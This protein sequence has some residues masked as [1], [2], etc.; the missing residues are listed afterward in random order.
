MVQVGRRDVF[1]E[2]GGRIRCRIRI[3]GIVQGVGFRPFVYNTATALGLCG[4]VL[5]D[6]RGVLVEAEGEP[7]KVQE[8]L[9]R[10][11]QQPPRLARIVHVEHEELAPVGYPR[12]EIAFS[13]EGAEKEALV[14]PDVALC[15]DCARESFDPRDRHYLYPFTNCTNCGPRFTIVIAVPYDRDKTSMAGFAMCPDCAREYHDPTNRRFHAQPVACPACGPQVELRDAEGNLVP[16]DWR[17]NCWRALAEGKIVALKSLGGFHLCCDAFNRQALRALRQRK[18]RSHKPFAVMCRDIATARRYCFVSEAEEEL[19]RS[20]QAPIVILRRRPDAPLPEELAPGLKTLGVMLPYTP[21]HLLLFDGPFALLVMTS[22]NYSELPLCKDNERVYQELGG[23]AD[24]FLLHNRPIVNRCD[25]SLAAVVGGEVQ[26]YRRSRGYVPRPVRVPTGEGPVVLG[27]GGEM[28]NTF[29]LLKKGEAFLSQHIGELDSLEGEENLFA[30]IV[31]FQRLLGVE[32][33]VVGYDLH[34][35]YRSSRIA[36]SIPARVRVGV[37]HHHAHLAACLAENEVTAPAIG[38][39]LDGTGYGEDGNLWGFEILS[40]DY[41]A[42]K[43]HFHLAYAPL[44]GGEQGIRQ[45]WRMAVSYLLTFLGDEGIG[46]AAALFGG[47]GRELE[48]VEYLVR[49]RFNSPLACGCGRLFDAVAAL[50]GICREATYEGQAAVELGETVLAPEEGGAISPYPFA[51]EGE[52]ISPAGILT[53]VLA[54]LRQGAA[55]EL[56][57][58]RFHNTV[59]AMVLEAAR[60]VREATGLIHV[61]LSGGTWQNRYLFERGKELLTREGFTV[62]CHRQVPPN[63]G[64]LSL[65]QAVIA[66]R[67]ATEC[68]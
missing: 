36:E 23:I 26:L 20:L 53:G 7:G 22:G 46:A 49:K 27:I 48:V 39:I 38:I 54:D 19:L 35:G 65:G 37:Q 8:L 10:I 30:S 42:F 28:K 6:A 32:P 55:R 33:E 60:K 47:K 58:T 66:Y 13:A 67:R 52:V 21:L 17:E 24:C 5:N 18:G 63:D 64:G 51:F 34:P 3:K 57:A 50:L 61:A 16:G 41:A 15:P 12:F 9:E 4:F 43:R 1:A 62:F 29:C 25:D 31:N 40:G 56:I 14:P 59:L 68:A 45:P 11:T 2:E 44:P